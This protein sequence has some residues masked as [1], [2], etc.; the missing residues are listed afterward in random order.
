MKKINLRELY[1]FYDQDCYIA[2]DD[3][4]TEIFEESRKAEQAYQRKVY[5]NKAHYS[6][7]REDGI[8]HA[9]VFVAISP[10]EYYEQKV[11]NGELYSAITRLPDLQA[12]R[13]YAHYF[14]G[15]S[16]TDIARAE[17]VSIK[18]VCTSI[19]RGLESIERNLKNSWT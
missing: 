15:M 12:K 1:P 5:R 6:L 16:K 10:W 18:A 7:N 13:I 11:T 9:T 17:G 2:V 19:T 14:L 8:E 3:T 4:V